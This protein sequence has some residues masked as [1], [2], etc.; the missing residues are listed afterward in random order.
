MLS[1][2]QPAFSSLDVRV[3]STLL[4]LWNVTASR[5]EFVFLLPATSFGVQVFSTWA[6]SSAILPSSSA[7]VVLPL[8][9][10]F[11]IPGAVVSM[12]PSDV[13]GSILSFV[14]RTAE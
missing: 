10:G 8:L 12:A 4:S 3:V 2:I 5:V 13:R 9:S 6:S 7:G 11:T 14:F 1:V